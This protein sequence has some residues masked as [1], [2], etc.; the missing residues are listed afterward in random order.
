MV[1][2]YIELSDVKYFTSIRETSVAV[3]SLQV[4][5]SSLNGFFVAAF[6]QIAQSIL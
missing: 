1:I 5:H 4:T 3:P 6:A 2:S